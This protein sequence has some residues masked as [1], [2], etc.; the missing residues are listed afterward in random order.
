MSVDRSLRST[1]A[2]ILLIAALFIVMNR[3]VASAPLADWFLPLA[4][5]IVGAALLPNWNFSRSSADEDEETPA[6]AADVHTYRIEAK[7]VPRLQTMTIRPDPESADY[8]VT[9][10]ED[11]PGDVLPFIETESVPG[12]TLTPPPAVPTTPA[13]APSFTSRNEAADPEN[14]VAKMEAPVAPAPDES[15]TSTAHTE[16]EKEVI[17]ATTAAPQQPYEV[18]QVGAITPEQVEQVMNDAPEA[19]SPLITETASPAITALERDGVGTVGSADDLVKL[20][21]IGPKSAAAL[22]A[23]GI[24]SFQKLANSSEDQLRAA[25]AGVRLV[26]DVSS[27]ARQAS[28]AAQGDWAGLNEFN[29]SQRKA[30]GD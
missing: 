29:A 28:Y 14:I 16:P 2:A 18:A 1:F 27:W 24:D 25:V 20:N 30:S 19:Q 12:I 11:T 3:I 26:G 9:I 6:L 7:P 13:P 8:T 4:L 22:K 23:A 17:A 21:G 5:F 10:T 15:V